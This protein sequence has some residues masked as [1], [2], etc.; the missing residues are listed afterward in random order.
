MRVDPAKLPGTGMRRIHGAYIRPAKTDVSP[1][2]IRFHTCI[3][4]AGPWAGEIARLAGIG[5][6]DGLL[7]VPLPIER[8]FY[9]YFHLKCAANISA[10]R[11]RYV[12][13]VH[14]PEGPGLDMPFL[15]DPSGVWCRRE[16]LGHTYLC[17]R[18]PTKEQDALI[19]HSNLDVDHDFFVEHVWPVLAARV[20]AFSA[21]KVPIRSHIVAS[22]QSL[23]VCR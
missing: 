6:G 22:T 20:P 9:L 2:P 17:G 19:D 12:Y 18:S 16:G 3:N 4:A 13:V 7:R 14:C 23:F 8:R 10:F 1:R 11:K 21:L 5:V 15:I